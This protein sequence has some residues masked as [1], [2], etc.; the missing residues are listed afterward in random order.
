MA[1]DYQTELTVCIACEEI[2]QLAYVWPTLEATAS[3]FGICR[4]FL[5]IPY[6]V[7]RNFSQKTFT[8][9]V[10]FSFFNYCIKLSLHS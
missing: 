7:P 9:I 4:H 2:L 8:F 5:S 10:Y 3:L 6:A 1:V